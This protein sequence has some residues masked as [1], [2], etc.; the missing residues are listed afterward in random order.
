MRHYM[1]L[2]TALIALGMSTSAEAGKKNKGASTEAAP[3]AEEGKAAEAEEA[4][5]LKMEETG[6]ADI[7]T[8]F[9]KAVSASEACSPL[10]CSASM[11]SSLVSARPIRTRSSSDSTTEPCASPLRTSKRIQL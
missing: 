3:A 11:I 6:V 5:G 1:I 7:D 4:T 10:T 8:L 2:A 9:G